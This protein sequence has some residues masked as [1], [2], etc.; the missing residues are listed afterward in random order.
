MHIYAYIYICI[1]MSVCPVYIFIY[2]HMY[3]FDTNDS[4]IINEQVRFIYVY[5]LYVLS[6]REWVYM[7]FLYVLF[8]CHFYMLLLMPI[9]GQIDVFHV[10]EIDFIT[11]LIVMHVNIIINVLVLFWLVCMDIDFCNS[12]VVI[13]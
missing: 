5:K 13:L 2:I 9:L 1:Y 6:W 7:S 4:G 12:H 3:I 11:P 8:I 10:Y